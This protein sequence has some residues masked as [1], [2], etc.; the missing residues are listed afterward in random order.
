MGGAG[1]GGCH[2]REQSL[3]ERRAPSRVLHT[4]S[5]PGSRV[6]GSRAQAQARHPLPPQTSEDRGEELTPLHSTK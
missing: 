2:Q 4:C 6:Q 1:G 3:R 5:L